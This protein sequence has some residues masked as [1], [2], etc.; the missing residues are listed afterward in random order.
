[1]APSM[2]P[3]M[4]P[5]T[6]GVTLAR[7]RF[8]APT[9]SAAVCSMTTGW[10]VTPAVPATS[11]QHDSA[12]LRPVSHNSIARTDVVLPAVAGRGG[13]GAKQAAPPRGVP[14]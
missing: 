13:F 3:S 1:M 6:T 14:R 12:D 11:Y 10:P 4:S 8:S 7:P 9:I 2:T 5:S